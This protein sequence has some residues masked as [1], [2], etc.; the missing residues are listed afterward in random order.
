M[1]CVE[2]REVRKPPLW[3]GRMKEVPVKSYAA[4]I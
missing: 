2:Q 3:A 1:G 4:V